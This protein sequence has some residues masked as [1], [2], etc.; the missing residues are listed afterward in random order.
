[1]HRMTSIFTAC[2][3]AGLLLASGTATARDG[4]VS[5]FDGKTLDGWTQRGGVA[6]YTVEDGAI[7]GRTVLNTPNSFL[8]T[9][10]NYADFELELEFLVDPKLNSGVQIRSNSYPAYRKGRVHGYQVE[11]DPSARAWSAGIYD[12][13]SGTTTASSPSA[14][15]SRRGSTVCPRRI[16]A[17]R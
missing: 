13:T 12:R 5:L 1:M 17:T 9:N 16:C 6:K 3:L 8:C 15:R 7:V 11:I 10:R 4:W 14:T 2:T